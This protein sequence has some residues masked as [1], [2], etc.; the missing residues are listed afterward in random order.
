M[1][2]ITAASGYET[3]S[4]A[5]PEAVNYHRWILGLLRPHLGGTVLEIGFGYGQYTRGMA[6]LADELVAVDLDPA[7]LAIAEELPE[8]VRLLVA[9]LSDAGFAERVG[10]ARFDAAVCLNVLEH[11]EDDAAA[12]ESLHACLRPG[13]RLLVFVP[14]HPALYGPMDRMAGHYRRYTR[15]VLRRRMEA[16]GFAL[17]KLQYVN[18]LGGLG[19]WANARFGRPSGLS[20]PAINR[21]ILWFDRYVQP[22]SR[23]LTPLGAG[24]FGQS[25][26]A[27]GRKG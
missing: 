23:W 24:L 11:V 18:P 19:W 14:A 27:V 5:L 17:A 7:C 12:L 21:Q 3:M 26:W 6:P 10:R 15:R 22:V 9:D 16:A 20:D 25:V 13:G 8:N 4:S 1:S 2:T